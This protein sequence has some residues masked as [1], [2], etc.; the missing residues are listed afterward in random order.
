MNFGAAQRHDGSALPSALT[1]L[2][3][4]ARRLTV[5]DVGVRLDGKQGQRGVNR[6]SYGTVPASTSVVPPS[7]VST[8]PLT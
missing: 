8:A 3:V 7:T 6:K 2:I 5:A 4:R 1:G